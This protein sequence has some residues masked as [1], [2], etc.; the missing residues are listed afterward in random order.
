M[1]RAVPLLPIWFIAGVVALFLTG[2]VVSGRRPARARWPW[3]FPE[4][5]SAAGLTLANLLFFW[6]PYRSSAQAP[7][8]G[9]D[10]TSFFYPIH[11]YASRRIQAGAVPFWDPSQYSGMPFLANFQTGVLYPPNLVAYFL[12]D[13]FSYAALERLALAHYLI[14]SL[15]TYWLVRALGLPRV[16]AV[17]AGVVFA[18][19]GFLVA[20]LGHYSM[21][22]TVAW[23][24]F[25]Y[26]SVI[27]AVRR[28]SWFIAWLGTP[29]LLGLILGGHQ[30]MLLMSLTVAVLIVL[31]EL[32]RAERYP[33]LARLGGHLRRRETWFRVAPLGVMAGLALLAALPVLGPAAEL[34]RYT[35][36]SSLSYEAASEYAAQPI[37]LVQLFLPTLFGSNPTDYWGA[38][39]T[40]EIWGYTG[41]LP[42]VLAGYGLSVRASRTQLFWGTLAVLA[43]LY[44]VGPATP[45]HGWFYAFAP[46]YDRVRAAGRGLMF[47]D[48]AVAVLSA[49]G[50]R[51]LLVRRP[52]WSVRQAAV[53][54]LTMRALLAAGG[55]AALFILLLLAVQVLQTAGSGNRPVVGVDNAVLL[56]FWLGLSLLV[57]LAARRGALSAGGLAAA[58]FAVMVVDL[59]HATGPFN[60]TTQPILTGF[61]HPQAVSYLMERQDEIGPFRIETTT[62]RW[63]PDLARLTGLED[64][65]GLVDPLSLASYDEYRRDALSDRGSERYRSLNV[66]YLITD[67]EQEPPGPL[68]EEALRT[69][70]GLVVW[71]YNDPRPRAWLAG[72]GTA[73]EVRTVRP[74][75]I[76]LTLPEEAAGEVVISQVDYPGWSATLD[77]RPIG[78]QTYDGALQAVTVP[79]GSREIVL[80]FQPSTWRWYV[81]GGVGAGLA[82][83]A[84]GVWLGVRRFSGKRR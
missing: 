5:A 43:L 64:I 45:L 42:L 46:G 59:F 78:V 26:A 65:S 31:F 40:T 10:L 73:V 23:A 54:R 4:V 50:L 3:L 15:G 35:A 81:A 56:C 57:L 34:T 12:A 25:V 24:P 48:L 16:C 76:R 38:W 61:Q 37:V 30:P 79:E 14:A 11:A 72:D 8:G 47:F 13:P 74:E 66:R 36:R 84:L 19:S 60:P 20:H 58:A 32:W 21:L 67:L 62:A 71:E 75:E 18:Y 63:Q 7:A 33:A 83:C 69:D 9:G 6:Q 29:A 39:T 22:S 80:T 77:G 82:W 44:A 68:F 1:D 51:S 41:I 28:R 52:Y 27:G 17:F 55:F 53:T 70:D 49:Y 2:L